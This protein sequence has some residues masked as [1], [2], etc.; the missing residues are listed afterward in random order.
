MSKPV[1]RGT[2]WYLKR[3]V[4]KRYASVEP[5]SVVW[6]S[7]K[8]DSYSVALQKSAGVWLSYI[9]GW[10][11]LL[12]GRDGDAAEKFRAAQQ[13]ATVRGFQ[14]LSIDQVERA[15]LEDVLRRVEATRGADGAP[16]EVVAAALLGAVED[17]KLRLSD[18]VDHVEQLSAYDNRFKN[19]EQM[20]LWRSPRLRAVNNLISALGQDMA[21]I[22]VGS[23]EARK[24]KS[25]WQ[26]RRAKEGQSAETANKDFAYMAGML[27]RFY[28][29]LEDDDPPRPYARISIHD[30]HAKPSQKREVPV[31]WIVEK[32]FAPDALSGLNDEARDILLISIETGCRQ[33][34]IY[35]LPASAIR[36]EDPIPH[37]RIAHEESENP[38]ER[39]EV[40]NL[41]SH[42]EIPLVG[43]ALAAAKRHPEGFPRYRN[44][45]S[46]SASVNKYLRNNGL[47]PEGVTIG[48]TRHSWE[49]R[50]KRAGY[51]MDDRGELMG[52]SLKARRGREVYGD[53][54]T[55]SDRLHVARE[56]MLPVPEHLK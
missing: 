29:D 48:G 10:E 2:T 38:E 42:R 3:R 11:A 27:A 35:N 20:R 6:A 31:D 5:R 40:K 41:P 52:H 18:L 17:P 50:M 34:E 45:S 32:W 23:A 30:R 22:D 7:L 43:V 26:A 15:P 21:V 9:E 44:K 19:R 24:H 14:F 13:M 55:L 46:Y 53:G 37:L 47:L 28:E 56:I 54:M 16:D 4:P 51:E 25:W 49:G 33:N 8:T 36:L 12:A 39:R 1:L